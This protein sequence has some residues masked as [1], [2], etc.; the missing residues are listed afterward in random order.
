MP[1]EIILLT[2]SVEGP[3]LSNVLHET[4]P[5]VIVTVVETREEL[6]AACLSSSQEGNRRSF[7]RLIAYCTDVIVPPDV[8]SGVT[9]P[10]YNFHPG[11]PQYPGSSASGFA[12]YDGA[13]SFGVCAHEMKETVDS[14][15]IVGVDEFE[16]DEKIRFVD[17]DLMA[18]RQLLALF[19]R[20]APQLAN[21]D[22]PLA[23]IDASW[24][25]RKTTKADVEAM[26]A[27]TADT[28]EEEIRL[29]WRAFG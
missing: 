19:T 24:G 16:I 23:V 29:R 18:Y 3:Y 15:A 28:S 13:K 20:L 27:I 8:L 2:G 21:N 6:R 1:T 14:G 7:R 4:N 11:P 5:D 26:K 25:T 12:I 22:A 9:K 17:L 10:A